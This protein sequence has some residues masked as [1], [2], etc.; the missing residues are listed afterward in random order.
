[1]L[2]I[3]KLM[4]YEFAAGAVLAAHKALVQPH[5]MREAEPLCEEKG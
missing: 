5:Y 1:M 4:A 3:L 2:K